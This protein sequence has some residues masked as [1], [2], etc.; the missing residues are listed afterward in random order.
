MKLRHDAHGVRLFEGDARELAT[1]TKGVDPERAVIICD[2]VWPNAPAGM[3]EVGDPALLFRQVAKSFPK[4]ARRVVVILG[5]NSDPRFLA[6][7]P[8]AL[9]CVRVIWL[10]Y[11]IPSARGTILNSGDLAYVFGDHRAQPGAMLI[12]GEA[13]STGSLGRGGAGPRGAHPCPRD[14]D[15]MRWLVSRLTLPGDVVIDPFA[16]SGTTLLA[17]RDHGRQAIGV[18]IIPKYCEVAETR[19]A[20]V[21]MFPPEEWAPRP[22]GSKSRVLSPKRGRRG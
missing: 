22:R 3:F 7:V 4:I 2:P 15:H 14:L 20:Q 10:R 5:C 1:A 17:A 9:K 12:P 11:E 21:P 6:G 19:L 13:T 18:E 16:G 8:K